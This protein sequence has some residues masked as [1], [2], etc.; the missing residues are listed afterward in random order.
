[1]HHLYRWTWTLGIATILAA[2]E[3]PARQRT[4]ED[5]FNDFTS[6]WIRANPNQAVSTRYFTGEEQDRLERQLTP[7]TLE[8]RRAR[9]QLARQGL[10]GLKKLDRSIM[11]PTQQVSADLMQWQL[12]TVVEGEPFLDYSFPLE[13][14]GG[15]NVS[16]VATLRVNHPLRSS[17]DAEN[18]IARLRQ[19]GTR[20]NEAVT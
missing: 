7:E 4:V 12:E 3:L 2:A 18:Y 17:K 10:V 20:M 6:Q 16:L 1:M 15:A 13:Q 9:I 19:V 11:T 14:F 8:Y 5:F